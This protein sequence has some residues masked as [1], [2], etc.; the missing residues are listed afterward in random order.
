VEERY[1][2]RVLARSSDDRA[3]LARKLG[4]SERTL[5]RKAKA[6]RLG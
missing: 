5:Y 3:E 2:R 1:L 6:L 4:I